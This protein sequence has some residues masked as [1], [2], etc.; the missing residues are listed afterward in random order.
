MRRG[1]ISCSPLK[2]NLPRQN[3]KLNAKSSSRSA[4]SARSQKDITIVESLKKVKNKV[5]TIFPR[6]TRLLV[7]SIQ[8]PRNERKEEGERERE[9]ETLDFFSFVR[10]RNFIYVHFSFDS[11]ARELK[12]DQS[13]FLSLFTSARLKRSR[14]FVAKA[15]TSRGRCRRRRKIVSFFLRAF[16][17]IHYF[18]SFVVGQREREREIFF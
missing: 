15:S 2:K 16:K 3:I 11:T 5:R 9:R 18:G 12:R 10:S 8:L 6:G 7:L 13:F 14:I 1:T 4:E 17:I